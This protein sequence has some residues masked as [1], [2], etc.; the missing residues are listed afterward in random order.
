MIKVEN[1][2][3]MGDRVLLKLISEEQEQGGIIMV[4]ASPL[5]KATVIKAGVG[6]VAN[7][8][9]SLIPMTVKEGDTVLVLN[10]DYPEIILNEQSCRLVFEGD[11][12]GII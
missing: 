10:S 1:Y 9:G 12:Q 8:T 5:L 3:P 6:K 7:D 4:G 2:V 11:I